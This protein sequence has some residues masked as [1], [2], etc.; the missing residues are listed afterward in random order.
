MD[1]CVYTERDQRSFR[2][3]ENAFKDGKAER[4]PLQSDFISIL[5]TFIKSEKKLSVNFTFLAPNMNFEVWQICQKQMQFTSDPLSRHL[6][7]RR[8]ARSEFAT[9]FLQFKDENLL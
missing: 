9:G 2:K 7:S 3:L 5:P 1:F 8:T 6:L 4:I